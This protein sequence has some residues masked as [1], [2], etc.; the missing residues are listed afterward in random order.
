MERSIYN[1]ISYTGRKGKRGVYKLVIPHREIREVFTLQIKEWFKETIVQSG[2]P[3]QAFCQAFLTGSADEIGNQLTI[4]LGKII[5]ILDAK[6]RND[7]KEN[8]YHG[9]LL[10]LLRSEITWLI[11]SNAESGDGFSDILIEPEAPG[12]EIVIEIKYASS[13]AGLDECCQKAMEQIKS[14]RYDEK[15]RNNGRENIIGYGIA[16]CKKRCKVVCEI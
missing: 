4:I 1:M 15:L 10:G 2:K 13:I 3:T 5:S 14:R 8:L 6:A 12:A 11:L 7:Q 9:L 16:F